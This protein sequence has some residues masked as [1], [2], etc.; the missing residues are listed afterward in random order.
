[1]IMNVNTAR[2]M[3]KEGLKLRKVAEEVNARIAS[4][5]KLGYGHIAVS[6]SEIY[7]LKEM[8]LDNGFTVNGNY[9]IW[10]DGITPDRKEYEEEEDEW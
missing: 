8:I 2:K 5:A 3:M 1:M 10:D 6:K 4:A 9:I 7:L